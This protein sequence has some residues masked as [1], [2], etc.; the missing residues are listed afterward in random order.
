[1]E[2][3]YQVTTSYAVFGVVTDT[4]G[5]VIAA[6]PIAKWA[7]G[8]NIRTVIKYFKSKRAKVCLITEL[9]L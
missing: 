6:A 2:V 7:I 4:E 8:K 1:M 5:R 3:L 9:S